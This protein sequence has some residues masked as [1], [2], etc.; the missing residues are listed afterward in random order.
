MVAAAKSAS[1]PI[2]DFRYG[3]DLDLFIISPSNFVCSRQVGVMPLP[4][5]LVGMRP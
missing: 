4:V 2:P 5:G 1:A 3:V